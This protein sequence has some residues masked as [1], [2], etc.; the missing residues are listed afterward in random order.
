MSTSTDPHREQYHSIYEEPEDVFATIASAYEVNL[1]HSSTMPSI[2]IFITDPDSDVD[3]LSSFSAA[4][5]SPATP[6]LSPSPISPL[7]SP[8]IAREL[9]GPERRARARAHRAPHQVPTRE[10]RHT[11]RREGHPGQRVDFA[12]PGALASSTPRTKASAKIRARAPTPAPLDFTPEP[13]ESAPTELQ[14][15]LLGPSK[16][17]SRSSSPS[18]STSSLSPS[19]SPSSSTSSLPELPQPRL[20]I[21]IP[22]A[23][24][25][26]WCSL[27]MARS[28]IGPERSERTSKG[29][30]IDA[31]SPYSKEKKRKS[32]RH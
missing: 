26:A 2:S 32:K 8:R 24:S 17:S 4:S 18:S 3:M 23:K 1:P 5:P 22:G 14:H 25:V 16:H 28:S 27:L 12:L 29:N 7:P 15:P 9:A 10:E 31:S 6:L 13:V 30:R 11:R 19:P 20:I 21:K